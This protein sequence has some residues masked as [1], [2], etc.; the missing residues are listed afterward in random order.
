MVAS[1][2]PSVTPSELF[3]VNHI[4]GAATL[5]HP[6]PML[7]LSLSLSLLMGVSPC[8]CPSPHPHLHPCLSCTRTR[9]WSCFA[10]VGKR[11]VVIIVLVNRQPVPSASVQ[12]RL[13]PAHEAPGNP[14]A[15]SGASALAHCGPHCSCLHWSCRLWRCPNNPHH[16]FSRDSKSK[17]LS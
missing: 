17:S 9:P 12:W 4:A 8:P 10:C 15:T 2:A 13:E 11:L 3:V 5:A 14:A 16:L 6:P 7:L 1:V